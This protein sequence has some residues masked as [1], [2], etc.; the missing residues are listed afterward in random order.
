MPKLP[1]SKI[2][3]RDAALRIGEEFGFNGPRGYYKMTAEEWIDW[4]LFEVTL[5]KKAVVK[6]V[7]E[8]GIK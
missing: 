1:G 3:W 4:A 7:T 5:Y 6:L 2:T 8:K